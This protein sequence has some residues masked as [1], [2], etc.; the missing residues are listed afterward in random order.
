MQIDW[1]TVF[2]QLVNFLV[3]VWLL[4]RFLYQPILDAIDAREQRIATTLSEAANTQQEARSEREKYQ[5]AI[6]ELEAQRSQLLNDATEAAQ[7]EHQKLLA[8][9]HTEADELSSK[10]RQD[11]SRELDK[12]REKIQ[13]LTVNEVFALTRKVLQELA[14]TS[15]EQS[16]TKVFTEQLLQMPEPSR[17]TLIT[18]LT[19]APAGGIVYSS[20]P[21]G[22][23]EQQRLQTSINDWA[24]T[25][26]PLQFKTRDTLICGMELN[27]KG[28]QSAWNIAVNLDLLE[29]GLATHFDVNES[30]ESAESGKPAE[31]ACD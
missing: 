22:A 11:Q 30:A 4:K 23:P 14:N 12:L 13:D 8:K 15:L 21:L 9:A 17:S 20:F 19:S 10:R 25:T 18:A 16:M 6:A 28:Q 26:V 1:F 27:A 3:L 5:S 29:A 2:A 24:K 7:L 31:S